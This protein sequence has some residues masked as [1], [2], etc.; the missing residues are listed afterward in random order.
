[1]DKKRINFKLVFAVFLLALC[2]AAIVWEYLFIK[3]FT[4]D[5]TAK[6]ENVTVYAKKGD[7]AAA[8]NAFEDFEREYIENERLL[9]FFLHDSF[10]DDT[11]EIVSAV[12]GLF[13][14]DSDDELFKELERLS[15]KLKEICE[16]ILPNL[17]NIM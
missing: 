4:D 9:S 7:L 2:T 17:R 12:E 16:S 13:S 14:S 11:K 15:Q 6:V 8:K 5:L 3:N 1:M 10:I